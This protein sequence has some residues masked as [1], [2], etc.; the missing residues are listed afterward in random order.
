[1]I[2]QAVDDIGPPEDEGAARVAQPYVEQHPIDAAERAGLK[3][4][5]PRVAPF[6]AVSDDDVGLVDPFPQP[7]EV[8]WVALA[9]RVEA[10]EERRPDQVKA[11]QDRLRI[12]LSAVA[13]LEGHRDLGGEGGQDLFRAIAA[14]VLAHDEV[15]LDSGPKL[16]VDLAD[17]ALDRGGLVVDRQDDRNR[18]PAAGGE[19]CSVGCVAEVGG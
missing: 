3:T 13:H 8:P 14:A 1:M 11:V 10:E 7:P 17:D 18:G 16:V 6:D 19:A 15:D 2:G 5:L 9:I 12:A 4:T